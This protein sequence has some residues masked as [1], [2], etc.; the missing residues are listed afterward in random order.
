[1]TKDLELSLLLKIIEIIQKYVTN[2]NVRSDI[3][4]ELIENFDFFDFDDFD[5]LLGIDSVLDEVIEEIKE[6]EDDLFLD[7]DM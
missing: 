5:E 6:E 1:M 2:E 7:D 4:Q 3:Y